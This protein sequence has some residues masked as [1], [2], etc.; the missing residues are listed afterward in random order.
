MCGIITIVSFKNH[1]HN[2]SRLDEMARMIK[3]RGPDD[4]GYALF[5]VKSDNYKI[6][7]GNDTPR[8]VIDSHLMFTPTVEY[9]YSSEHFSVGLAHR[10]LSIIDLTASG[11]QPMCDES[12]RYWIVFNG[13][14]Y[15]YEEIKKE[16]KKIG[17][18]FFSTCDTEVILKS[19]MAWGKECQ[20][21][22]NGM[23][24]IVIWDNQEKTL[25]ISRDRFGI[26]PLYYTLSDDYIAFF[27]EAK[28]L[29]PISCLQP[30]W[31]E[32]NACLFD[33]ASESHK[34]TLFKNVYRFPSASSLL[35]SVNNCSLF[36]S[37]SSF[38]ELDETQNSEE[39]LNKNKC[40][41]YS[42]EYLSILEDAVRLRLHAD[43]KVG[44]ALSGGLDSS[45]ITYLANRIRKDQ[46]VY[47]RLATISSVYNNKDEKYCDESEFIDIIVNEYNLESFRSNPRKDKYF[48][49]N[50]KGTW[51]LENCFDGLRISGQETF[52][53]AQ[54]NGIGVT[55]DGQGADEQLSG[56]LK[57][58][59]NYFYNRPRFSCDYIKSLFS[60]NIR[61][62]DKLLYFLKI[63]TV[64]KDSKSIDDYRVSRNVLFTNSYYVKNNEGLRSSINYNLKRLLRAIDSNS[65]SF[66]VESRQPFMDYRL[67]EF[68]NN[69]PDAY[70]IYSGWTKY[71]ARIAFNNKLPKK[72]CW[73]KDKI[74]WAYPYSA[75]LN[76][77]RLDF[78]INTIEN[79]NIVNE[80]FANRYDYREM[81]KNNKRLFQRSYNMAVIDKMFFG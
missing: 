18:S 56:Y 31:P 36:P 58:W 62:R 65:M 81:S 1:K 14:I 67:V 3:H 29:R 40:R 63:N 77:E 25:W 70:K 51:C 47:D 34:Y 26:K 76:K 48:E 35:V 79:S 75:F 69:L 5:D 7:S 20:N 8:S 61:L 27:S 30:F 44:C 2:L 13:E 80:T 4:E 45:S 42:E 24:A 37:F 57:Y 17:Y 43:V 59:Y 52:S 64:V 74:G 16:L 66:S 23:W 15:N 53:I 54:R 78:M 22:F 68:T 49:M 21:K 33:G 41:A 46:S 10:R 19:Y 28:C 9:Q 55:L 32:I 11:H 39:R 12:G 6:F 72:I 73:R 71:I 38:W 50:D 60:N